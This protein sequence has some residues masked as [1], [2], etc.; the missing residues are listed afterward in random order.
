MRVFLVMMKLIFFWLVSRRKIVFIGNGGFMIICN[1]DC[2]KCK[3]LNVKVD[4]Q[5]YP[6]GYECLKYGD[7]VFQEEF[8]DTKEFPDFSTR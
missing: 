4:K 5:G 1:G 3:Q 6:W 8:K 7:S 2:E